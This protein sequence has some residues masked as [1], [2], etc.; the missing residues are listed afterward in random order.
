MTTNNPNPY[1]NPSPNPDTSADTNKN[2]EGDNF[3]AV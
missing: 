1:S 2:H 3:D